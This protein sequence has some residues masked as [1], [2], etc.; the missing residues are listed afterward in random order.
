VRIPRRALPIQLGLVLGL[1][2]GPA[3][4]LATEAVSSDAESSKESR[5]RI[6]F[7]SRPVTS[8]P[9]TR[10]DG[11][12][13]NK[14]PLPFA[15]LYDQTTSMNLNAASQNFETANDDFDNQA[16]DDFIVT[17]GGWSVTTVFAPGVYSATHGTP[18]SM[19]VAFYADAGGVPGALLCDFP[20]AT[21]V[22]APVGSFLI[23][24][25]GGCTLSP[26]TKWVSVV[27]NMAFAGGA[28]GQWFWSTRTVL[29]GNPS[30][31]QNPGGGF[32]TPCTTW[33]TRTTCLGQSDPD[34]A[35]RL[36]GSTLTCTVNA[37]CS[38]GNLC[39]GV[40]TCSAGNCQPGTPVSCVDGLVCTL[41]V[42]NPATGTCSHPPNPCSDGD[43]CTLDTC[44]EAQGCSHTN[45]TIV[46]LCNAGPIAIPTGGTATPY[47]SSIVVSGLPT[48]TSVCSVELS[49]LSHTFPDDV[50]VMVAGPLGGASNAV[51]MSDVG[52]D[53]PVTNVSLILLDAAPAPLPDSFE[54]VSGAFKP[55]NIG[56]GDVFP[57]PAPLQGGS[58]LSVFDATNPNGTWNLFV[59]DQ[60]T[61]DGGSFSAGWCINFALGACTVDAD[62]ADGDLCNGV[63][64]C[65]AGG[66]CQT[67][68]PIHCEDTDI[69]TIDTCTPATGACVH[70]AD[71]C[72]DGN[73]CT[74]DN[75][76]ES[77][78]CLNDYQ[79]VQFCSAPGVTIADSPAPPTVAVPYPSVIA[80]SGFTLP[81]VLEQVDFRITHT[82]PD[83]VDM[84]LVGPGGHNAIIMSDVGGGA[85]A[86]NVALA[87]SDAGTAPLPDNGPL[88]SGVFR[89]ANFA[90]ADAWPAPAPIPTGGSALSVF[91]GTNPNG[92]WGL[93]IVD[94]FTDDA[95]SLP[96][97]WCVSLRAIC[98]VNAHCDDGNPC[99]TDTCS[100][101]GVCNRLPNVDACD[102]A[103][104]CTVNDTC[105]FGSCNPGTPAGPPPE[106]AGLSVAAD[107]VTYSWS[108][109]PP[110]TDYDVLRASLAA[111]PIGP[112]GSDETCFP[113]VGGTTVTDGSVPP[114]GTGYGYLARGE[115]TCGVGTYGKQSNGTPR[116]STTCP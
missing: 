115:W 94:A 116:V 103:N 51:I 52:G 22:E 4:T 35:F 33:G 86:T 18:T 88:V 56:G 110:A 106:V 78:G 67:G 17:G 84:L 30:K 107:K 58:A 53:T 87:L 82:F 113:N 73:P 114:L 63:E 105:S 111:L 61:P 38:D 95:G 5:G 92:N 10:G 85:D 104:P 24:L 80:V 102:D 77:M 70:T 64:T 29:T 44:T 34:M 6:D 97:P 66:V 101:T 90:P 100:A 91:T 81:A 2:L 28:G 65:G 50:D 32:G 99:T 46:H 37:D 27:A 59:V 31:W 98:A 75:C 12:P 36:E 16:A 49:G 112:G 89:P 40:E 41:D 1:V 55:T 15:V 109:A 26:G 57:A 43:S 71:P 25:P 14:L 23:T 72:N 93:Y 11:G 60:F 48:T 47:P 62:C 19:R 69:C 7:Q 108:A 9:V 13:P 45:A 79:C 83:D 39:N 96:G 68:T 42:C 20:T 3:T 76:H 8:T 54:L 74:V 21:F